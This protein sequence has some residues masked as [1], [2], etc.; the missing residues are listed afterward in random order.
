MAKKYGTGATTVWANKDRSFDIEQGELGIILGSSGADKPTLL[1]ILGGMESTIDGKVVVNGNNIAT[2]SA[3]KLIKYRRNEISF[4]F[5]FYN[6]VPNL[7]AKE[8]VVLVNELV[9]NPLDTEV[10][11]K[12]VGLENRI[13]N[14]PL[15]LKMTFGIIQSSLR[16]QIGIIDLKD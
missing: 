8:N 10:V 4:V 2:S 16:C 11:L 15:K 7:T 6:L 5:Q 13:N 14:F 1:N 12:E 3:K 9:A